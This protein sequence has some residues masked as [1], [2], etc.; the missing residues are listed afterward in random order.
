[1]MVSINGLSSV[2]PANEIFQ[3]E[4]KN[5]KVFWKNNQKTLNN[6]LII[7]FESYNSLSSKDSSIIK[8][9]FKEEK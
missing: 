8:C 4:I 2:F 5:A 9:T 1:M 7:N 3:E 6:D